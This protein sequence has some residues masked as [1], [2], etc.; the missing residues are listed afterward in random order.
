MHLNA[1]TTG[2]VTLRFSNHLYL[3]M[4]EFQTFS[5]YENYKLLNAYDVHTNELGTVG[6][7]G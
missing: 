1:N 6:I 3:A 7:H 5:G 2:L 4:E